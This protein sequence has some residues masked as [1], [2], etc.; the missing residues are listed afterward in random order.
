MANNTFYQITVI[1]FNE[2]IKN[3]IYKAVMEGMY[4]KFEKTSPKTLVNL[5]TDVS[6]GLYISHSSLYE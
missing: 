6:I 3:L 4:M 2:L 1:Y 5:F